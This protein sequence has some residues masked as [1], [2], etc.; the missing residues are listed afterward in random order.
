MFQPCA[1]IGPA[2]AGRGRSR[3]DRHHDSPWRMTGLGASFPAA[4]LRAMD[5][6]HVGP[7]QLVASELVRSVLGLRPPPGDI[8][9]L[10]ATEGLNPEAVDALPARRRRDRRSVCGDRG[11]NEPARP[12]DH[13][14]SLTPGNRREPFASMLSSRCAGRATL[15]VLVVQTARRGISLNRGRRSGNRR[16]VARR[17]LSGA[18]PP[19]GSHEGW[20]HGARGCLPRDPDGRDPVG[21]VVLLRSARP[22]SSAADDPEAEMSRLTGRR[23][24]CSAAWT[25]VRRCAKDALA[26]I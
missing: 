11:G 23:S 7:G 19:D 9:E 8:L 15:G 2:A 22:L 6:R 26:L 25:P 17:M 5:Q 4:N 1:R 24:A 14:P 16:H 20:R 21:P 13:P 10:A 18:A 12:T 3:N